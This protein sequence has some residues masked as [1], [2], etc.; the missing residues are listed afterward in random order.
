MARHDF[1]IGSPNTATVNSSRVAEQSTFDNFYEQNYDGA[2]STNNEYQL[3]ILAGG[4]VELVNV[5]T[6]AVVDT[7]DFTSGEPFTIKGMEFSLTGGVGDTAQFSLNQPEKKNLAQTVNDLYQVLSTEGLSNDAYEKARND[8]LVG[9]DNGLEKV[10]LERSSV[11]GRLSTAESIYATN[12]DLDVATKASRSAI[13]DV[14]F[15]EA[16]TEFTKQETALNATLS[17]FSKVT[18]LSLFN[19]I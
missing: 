3:N 2:D 17:S 13:E 19:Y 9:L 12:I 10:A 1:T 7:V 11:G 14:D 6:S 5:G 15:A 16:A 18:S 4:R 8:A